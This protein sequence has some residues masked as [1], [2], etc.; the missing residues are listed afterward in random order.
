PAKAAPLPARKPAPGQPAARRESAR[1]EPGQVP[2]V[3]GRNRGELQRQFGSPVQEREAP[4]ARVLEFGRADCRLAVYLYFDT[5][6]NDFYALQYEVNDAA[7]AGPAAEQCLA[8][9]A[10][11]AER[12]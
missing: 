5:A 12:R 7:P 4:P 9:I 1:S 2:E 10:R 11:D 8:R 3:I 6:R